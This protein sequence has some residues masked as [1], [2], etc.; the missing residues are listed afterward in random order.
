MARTLGAQQKIITL[1]LKPLA[2]IDEQA[3]M[4]DLGLGRTPIRECAATAHR[5]L[6]RANQSSAV[7][8]SSRDQDRIREEGKP[9]ELN[10]LRDPATV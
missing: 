9:D 6:P 8:R 10:R 1:E 5:S 7:A 2:V 3:L 4:E